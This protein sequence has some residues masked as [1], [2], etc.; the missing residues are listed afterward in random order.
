MSENNLFETRTNDSDKK[1]VHTASLVLGILSL[2][3]SLLFALVGEILGI[4]GI[5]KA[6]RN[7]H[8]YS[9]TA[10]LVCSIIG[11]VLAVVNHIL[12]IVL[13]FSAMT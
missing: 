5:V 9:T 1:P 3:F 11:L 2:V 13:Q 7:R 4:I 8:T 12:G 10:A 6:S